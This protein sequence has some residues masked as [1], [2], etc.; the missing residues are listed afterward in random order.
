[1]LTSYVAS[2]M[3]F[4]KPGSYF[5]SITCLGWGLPAALGVG[6]ASS[7]KPVVAL[8]GDGSAL[9]GIQALWTAAKYKIPVIMVVLNNRGYAAVKWGLASYPDR[10]SKEGIDIEYISIAD[11]ETLEDVEQIKDK[12]LIA[13]ACHVGKTRLIDN[14][15]LT[16][17]VKITNLLDMDNP[18][19]IYTNSGD[20]SF[21]FDQLEAEKINPKL[22][23]NTLDEFY[24]DSGFFSEPRRVELGFSYNF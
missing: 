11:P 21:T 3:D 6:L 24:T 16:L 15:V 22:Y 2:I 19:G 13:I 17:F 1:M 7:R 8:V 14:T 10:K 18:T 12:A 5:C 9:F 4:T 20:P 23:E